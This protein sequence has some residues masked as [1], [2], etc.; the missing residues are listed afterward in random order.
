MGKR[1]TLYLG[2]SNHSRVATLGGKING[3]A[4]R[5]FGAADGQKQQVDSGGYLD[6]SS[7]FASLPPSSIMSSLAIPGISAEQAARLE[8]TLRPAHFD[9]TA[10]LRPNILALQ[11]YRCARDDYQEGI[12]LD[13][14]E[15]SLGHGLPAPGEV[16]SEEADLLHL[17]LHRYPDPSLFGVKQRLAFLRGVGGEE[18]VMLGVGSDEVLD[19]IQ[20]IVGRPGKDKILACPP[21]YGMYAVCAA[22]N[23][24]EVV[25]VPLIV[26]PAPGTGEGGEK[27]R[28]ALDTDGILAALEKDS[29]IKAVFLCSPGNPTGTLLSMR[30]IEKIANFDR[31]NGLVV[32]D[33]AYID[34]A[35]QEVRQGKRPAEPPV[36]AVSLVNKYANVVVTE[37]LSKA[38][39]LA[40]VRYVRP[41]CANTG[42]ADIRG[43]MGVAYAS[44]PL[45]QIMNNTK[46]PYNVSVPAARLASLALSDEGLR[47]VRGNLTTLVDNRNWLLNALNNIPALGPV[48]GSNDANFVL[49]PVMDRPRTEAGAKPDSVRAGQV[50]KVMAEKHGVVV[51]DRSKELGCSG[52]LRITVGTADENNQL[53]QLLTQLLD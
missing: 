50:Y 30:A 16:E 20:R 18:N 6:D 37:T 38:Y 12:L 43:S 15:N 5:R 51:R 36:S 42:D 14:N 33:Q 10:L 9:L 28:F 39:G 47:K 21:T 46:A 41:H 48:K 32:V 45:I 53:I 23:E 25:K 27:G 19:L 8:A 24:L 40:G 52:C 49:V 22:V 13:A 31:W 7:S 35:E 44:A 34:F 3:R 11:P 29:S 4:Y 26:D 1:E 2:N 17:P